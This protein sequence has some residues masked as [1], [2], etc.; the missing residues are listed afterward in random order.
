[1]RAVSGAVVSSK[2]LTK[3]K[4]ARVCSLFAA[5]DASRLSADAGALVLCAA[6]AAAELDAFRRGARD[7]DGEMDA[8]PSG[9]KRRKKRR[10][11]E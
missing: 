1:M 2:P 3:D 4:A 10:R 5:T 6:E 9:E 8:A 11:A 7:P